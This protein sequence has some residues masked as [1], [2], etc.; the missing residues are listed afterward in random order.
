LP[1]AGYPHPAVLNYSHSTF[2]LSIKR[3]FILFILSAVLIPHFVKE[4]LRGDLLP[5]RPD[6]VITNGLRGLMLL[7][8]SIVIPA[9]AGIQYLQ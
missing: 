3:D 1:A 4:G 9:K 6:Q 5:A 2:I 7:N 8:K